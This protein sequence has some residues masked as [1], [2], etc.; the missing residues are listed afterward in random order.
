MEYLYTKISIMTNIKIFEWDCET[1]EI[2]CYGVLAEQSNPLILSEELR[3]LLKNRIMNQKTPVIYQDENKVIFCGMREKMTK[4]LLLGP[5]CIEDMSY[6]EI[7][8]YCKAYQIENEQCPPKLK[9]QN[10]LA[11][12]ELLS[13]I[14]IEEKYEDEEILDANGLIEKQEIGLEA[15]VRIDIEDIYHHTYQEE[16]KTM[17]YIREGNLE[18][19]VGAVEL[20]ASTAGKL[21]E[22][23]I[24]NERN[25]GIC[26]ITLATRAAIEGGAAPAKAYKLS[27]LYI[28]KIDQCKRMTEIFEYR[29]RSLY[30]FAKLVVEER[31]KRANSRYTEQCKEYIRKYYHQKICIPD[32]AEALGVSESH[33]SRIFKKE[34]GESIQKYSMHMRIERAEN[35]LKYSEASLT[36]ISEYLC[37]SS[38]SHFGKVFK[39]Y[40]NMTPKQYRDYY[41]SP[42]FVSR[43]EI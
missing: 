4:M 27:D 42:E 38:Q 35:L 36:E 20:L 37:F 25:L 26:S 19:V 16:V 9:L 33:L 13:Y 3:E 34:T 32:I 2:S 39:V 43:E 29:K 41:K 11:L 10:L 18:E 8:R 21:S 22:N 23:E 24:R 30:D 15:D 5:I 6:V 17:D 28:N 12:L 40:K 14:K 31:E 7:H 1:D